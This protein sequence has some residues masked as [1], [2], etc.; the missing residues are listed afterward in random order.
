MQNLSHANKF[1]LNENESVS[2]TH[3]HLNSFAQR[4][5]GFGREAKGNS[6][7]A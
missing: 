7:M 2:R 6:E 3:C 4:L 1:E 5:Y